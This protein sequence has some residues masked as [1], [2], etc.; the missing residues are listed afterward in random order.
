MSDDQDKD[1]QDKDLKTAS[2]HAG[3]APDALWGAISPPIVLASS[4]AVDPDAVAF[5]ALDYDDEAP[6]FYSRWSNPTLRMLEQKIAALEGAGDAVVFGSGMAAISGLWQVGPGWLPAR[7]APK[8]SRLAPGSRRK[9]GDRRIVEMVDED[10]R[11][12]DI[13]TPAAFKNVVATVLAV[14]GSIN[15]IKHLQATAVEAENGVDVFALWEEMS[16]VPVLC[17]VRPTGSV[18][19]EQFEDAG[20]ARAILKRLESR[21]EDPSPGRRAP[22]SVATDGTLWIGTNQNRH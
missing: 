1:R 13:L 9:K 17:P 5:S 14:S 19:I 2:I 16:D 7:L 11:P 18:R 4:F 3:E 12:R 22:H 21:I 20:A 15:A 6:Y 10:L 8:M